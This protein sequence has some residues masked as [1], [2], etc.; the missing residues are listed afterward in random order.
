[1]F[2][3]VDPNNHHMAIN[4]HFYHYYVLLLEDLT[5]STNVTIGIGYWVSYGISGGNLE[6]RP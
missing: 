1:M 6:S 3:E 4:F 5:F 2:N